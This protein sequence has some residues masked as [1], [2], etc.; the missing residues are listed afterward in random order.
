MRSDELADFRSGSMGRARTN[1]DIVKLLYAT[2]S[3]WR[4]DPM[5]V[6]YRSGRT[7]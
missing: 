7:R 2:E 4:Y 1:L 5:R 3:P 6:R